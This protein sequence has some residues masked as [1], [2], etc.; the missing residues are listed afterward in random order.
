MSRT[1]SVGFFTV[2]GRP[3]CTSQ[4]FV[5]W[6]CGDALA[7]WFLLYLL[8]ASREKIREL[9]SGA[10]HKTIYFP[11][12]KNFSVCVPPLAEQRRLADMLRA[13]ITTAEQ[14]RAA[15]EAELAAVNA[16]PA[17]LLRRAFNGEL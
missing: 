5:N 14:A 4:D 1:A 8:I 17:A 12:V 9:G 6:V 10:V 2:M 13:Q 3:M 7:P 15:A 11:T 16:L